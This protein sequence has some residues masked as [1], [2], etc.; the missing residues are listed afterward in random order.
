MDRNYVWDYQFCCCAPPGLQ[1]LK[2]LNASSN[3]LTHL[4]GLSGCTELQQLVSVASRMLQSWHVTASMCACESVS[5]S[6]KSMGDRLLKESKP[7]LKKSKPLCVASCQLFA[8]VVDNNRIKELDGSQLAGL[9]NLRLIRMQVR[10][11][12]LRS[13][14]QKPETDL[15]LWPRQTTPHDEPCFSRLSLST[16]RHAQI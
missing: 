2:M 5:L 8:Q 6:V 14:C 16:R 11:E 13:L 10:S 3:E 1:A 9:D 12:P 7:L 4:H 15:L